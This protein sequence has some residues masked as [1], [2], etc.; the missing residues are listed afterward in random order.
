MEAFMEGYHVMKTHPQLQQAQPSLYN[1]RYGNETGGIGALANP[2]LGV[3]ENIQEALTSMDLLGVGMGGLVQEKEIAIAR[4]LADVELPDD[5]QAAMMTWYR[6]VCQAITTQLRERGEDVPDLAKVMQ[7]QPV[8]AVEFLFPHYFL[9]TY[10]TSM[11]SYRIRPLG[12]ESCLFE[13]WSLTQYPEGEEPEP[14]REPT[15]LPFDSQEFP[16]IPRQDYSNIPIQQKGMHSAGFEHLRLSKE[17]EGLISNYHRLIDGYI[18]G[19]PPRQLAAA[20]RQL[21]GNFD[22]P[23]LDLGL[24]PER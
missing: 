12:P 23:I 19:A 14:V 20:N 5:P 17:R 16:M 24:D 4:Q 6:L 18:D 2:N 21:G 9:L 1:S 10:F 7:E 22:G 13:L 15:M 11:S 3:R 8:E